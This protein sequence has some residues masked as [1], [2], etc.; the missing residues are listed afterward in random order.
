MDRMKMFANTLSV[1]NLAP[2][3]TLAKQAALVPGIPRDR[4][5]ARQPS[6]RNLIPLRPNGH[7][8]YRDEKLLVEVARRVAAHP[9]VRTATEQSVDHARIREIV[10]SPRINPDEAAIVAAVLLPTAST[11]F[12]Q[13]DRPGRLAAY[14]GMPV[15][16]RG[17]WPRKRIQQSR[18]TN[19][20]SAAYNPSD[21]LE[22]SPETFWLVHCRSRI[23]MYFHQSEWPNVRRSMPLSRHVFCLG[24][25][26]ELI[27]HPAVVVA[28][29]LE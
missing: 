16:V 27:P 10:E 15:L 6:V 14:I 24:L 9:D 29:L 26:T 12:D 21:P 20:L 5:R 2:V 11:P 22:E 18:L 3:E 4:S 19:P 25:L 8:L 1:R 13:R 28:A 23:Q 7:V 17:L